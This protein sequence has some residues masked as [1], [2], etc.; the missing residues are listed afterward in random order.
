MVKKAKATDPLG[1][2]DAITGM[3]SG[4]LLAAI[5]FG[6]VFTILG[7]HVS[8]MGIEADRVCVT[9]RNVPYGEPVELDKVDRQDL[10]IRK[11][12]DVDSSGTS[13][14]DKEPDA[15]AHTLSVL[16]ALPTFVVF[17]GFILLT[18]RTIR[19][20]QKHGLFSA[21]LAERIERLGWLLLFG[22]IGAAL[23]EWLTEGQLLAAMLRDSG[24]VS[25]SFG[26]SVPGIIGAYGLVSIGRIMGH[27]ATLQAEA[28]ATI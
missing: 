21:T 6:V 10:G 22:L 15:K 20:A 24:W 28:D 17:L 14:C 23:I 3:I 13:V 25:G 5:A 8:V 12:V 16:T 11:H 7:D 26:V 27:A 1:P 2:L 4:F 18:H 9:T 19:H